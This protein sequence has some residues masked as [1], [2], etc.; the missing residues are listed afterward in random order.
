MTFDQNGQKCNRKLVVADLENLHFWR[1]SN[2]VRTIE[3]IEKAR[4]F[5]YFEFLK[6]RLMTS[7]FRET[8]KRP[9]LEVNQ[10]RNTTTTIVAR[11]TTTGRR[12]Y[13][14]VLAETAPSCNDCVATIV[15]EPSTPTVKGG[16][17]VNSAFRRGNKVF[18]SPDSG[19]RRG[20]ET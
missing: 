8:T 16:G 3:R 19:I 14:R 20:L 6:F 9:F 17:T 10:K 15:T 5:W 4:I 11:E 12:K 13:D 2:V 1:I 7:Y 18:N